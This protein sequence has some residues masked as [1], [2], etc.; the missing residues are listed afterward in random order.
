MQDNKSAFESLL[1]S[2]SE[3]AFLLGISRTML[4]QMHSSGLLGPM[5]QKIGRRSLIN[6]SELERWVDAG[7]P[8]RVQWQKGEGE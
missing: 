1:V 7:L 2:F 6:R 3:A 5:V 8:P 4:Y